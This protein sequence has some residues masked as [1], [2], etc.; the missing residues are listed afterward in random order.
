M[1]NDKNKDAQP[2]FGNVIYRYT[3]DEAIEDGVLVHVGNVGKHRVVFANTLFVQGYEDETK[4]KALIE[5][6][7]ELLC[8]RDQEDSPDRRHRVIE[9]DKIWVIWNVGEG[10]T[11]LTPGDY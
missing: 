3:Q 7:L 6:G 9:K 11:F 5:Q 1:N 8:G 2:I 4:R 10:F